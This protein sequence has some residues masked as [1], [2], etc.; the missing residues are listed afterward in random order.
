MKQSVLFLTLVAT[1]VLAF[2]GI[3][4]VHA[5]QHD[6]FWSAVKVDCCPAE[7]AVELSPNPTKDGTITFNNTET[8]PLHIYVFDAEGT[9]L[10]QIELKE[11]GKHTIQHLKKG[12]YPFDVFR[13]EVSV[14]RG[15]I[16]SN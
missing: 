9:L 15:K 13:D 5:H 8:E 11:K 14:Q 3:T 4:S 6:S 7:K 2:A 10:H 12:I 1:A 16:F